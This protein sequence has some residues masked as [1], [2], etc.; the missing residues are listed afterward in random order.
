MT[1]A[2]LL[3]ELN[4]RRVELT[5]VG[6][7]LHYR[8]PKGTLTPE[9]REAVTRFREEI[10]GILQDD[11][12][13]GQVSQDSSVAHV[14]MPLVE[15]R[16]RGR[17]EVAESASSEP[18]WHCHGQKSCRCALCAVPALKMRWEEGQCRA[19]HGS[20]FLCWPEREI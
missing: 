11:R 15:A 2:E 5:A 10:L 7:R 4:R 20:G 18:C 3:P 13:C 6:D 14:K 19:C 9:L 1:V 8:A 16:V 17:G 12:P